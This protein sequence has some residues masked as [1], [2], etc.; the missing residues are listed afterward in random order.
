[1]TVF[2]ENYA[3]FSKKDENALEKQ[4][5]CVVYYAFMNDEIVF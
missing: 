3:F 4:G 5:E 1:M 2:P